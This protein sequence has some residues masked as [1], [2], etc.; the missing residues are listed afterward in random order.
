M[1]NG[2]IR[3]V[4]AGSLVIQVVLVRWSILFFNNDLQQFSRSS[5]QEL[6]TIGDRTS[7]KKL[8]D[9]CYHVFLDVGANI[10]VHGR[11]LFE[12]KKY[13]DATVASAI[14]N[15]Q[16]GEQRDNRDYCVFAVEPNPSHK[17][18]LEQIAAAYQKMGWRYHVVSAGADAVDGNLTF[19]RMNDIGQKE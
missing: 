8:G 7:S 19:Y 5:S 10:G 13:P 11:F 18:R 12:P 17:P 9:G 16:F 4:V 2:K 15:E 3:I 14:F 1:S 6:A